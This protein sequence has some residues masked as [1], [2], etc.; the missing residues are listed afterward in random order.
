MKNFINHLRKA[1]ME[2]AV[3]GQAQV[4]SLLAAI[5]ENNT[6]GSAGRKRTDEVKNWEKVRD[7]FNKRGH[8]E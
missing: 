1:E 4:T 2:K 6:A 8:S 3:Q 7:T 5:S